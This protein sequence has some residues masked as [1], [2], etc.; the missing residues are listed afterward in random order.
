MNPYLVE[1]KGLYEIALL[2]IVPVKQKTTTGDY[3]N[4]QVGRR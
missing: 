2:Q 3:V 4:H 1:L